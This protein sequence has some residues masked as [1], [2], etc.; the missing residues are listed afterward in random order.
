MQLLHSYDLYSYGL[1]AG[2]N[3]DIVM[4][5]VVMAYVVIMAYI[6]WPCNSVVAKHGHQTRAGAAGVFCDRCHTDYVTAVSCTIVGHRQRSLRRCRL[7]VPGET[8]EM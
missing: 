3:L 2:R 1:E 6:V 8:V 5:Y 4:A 7:L